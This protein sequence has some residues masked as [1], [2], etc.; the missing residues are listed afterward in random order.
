MEH[1]VQLAIRAHMQPP[2][3]HLLVQNVLLD[4]LPMPAQRPLVRCVQL[5]LTLGILEDPCVIRAKQ[6]HT[7]RAQGHPP[8]LSVLLEQHLAVIPH[9]ARLVMQVTWLLCLGQSTA[10]SVVLVI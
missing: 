4:H 6:G 5:D 10:T 2:R 8:V 7:A 1:R 9:H 3:V